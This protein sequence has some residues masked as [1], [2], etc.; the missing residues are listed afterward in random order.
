MLLKFFA[1][2]TQLFTISGPI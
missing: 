1:V 2:T